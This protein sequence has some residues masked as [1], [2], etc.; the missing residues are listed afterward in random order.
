MHKNLLD[1]LG[2]QT[3]LLG[4]LT[5]NASI[6]HIEKL[7]GLISLDPLVLVSSNGDTKMESVQKEGSL[8]QQ[9]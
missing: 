7:E 3:L 1:K 2:V 9:L 5:L 4:N 8:W 6:C